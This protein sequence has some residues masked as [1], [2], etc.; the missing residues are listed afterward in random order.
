MQ[1]HA[2]AHMHINDRMQC[3]IHVVAGMSKKK[4][5]IHHQM[6]F[7][8]PCDKNVIYEKTNMPCER[9]NIVSQSSCPII[10]PSPFS[11]KE[12]TK[13]FIIFNK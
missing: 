7:N 1:K 6:L 11:L 12:N 3:N 9:T 5:H 10:F 4:T 8:V 13:P 2:H